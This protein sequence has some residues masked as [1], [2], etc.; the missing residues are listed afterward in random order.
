MIL[1]AAW[2]LGCSRHAKHI[3][4]KKMHRQHQN[5]VYNWLMWNWWNLQITKYAKLLC[6]PETATRISPT[7]S[8]T[9]WHSRKSRKC[10]AETTSCC[11]PEQILGSSTRS[12]LHALNYRGCFSRTAGLFLVLLFHQPCRLSTILEGLQA[13]TYFTE[14]GHLF[15]G[16]CFCE[17]AILAWFGFRWVVTR[18]F[19]FDCSFF[20]TSCFG[21]SISYLV[22]CTWNMLVVQKMIF[23]D[24]YPRHVLHICNWLR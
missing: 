7:V 8:D 1:D 14:N 9:Q 22:H 15:F 10:V 13:L 3:S 19:Y 11:H 2:N 21:E 17:G 5:L 12:A 16:C 18:S 23:K 6:T 4:A 24:R 20:I